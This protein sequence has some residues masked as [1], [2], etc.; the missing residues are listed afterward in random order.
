MIIR[1]WKLSFILV[2]LVLIPSTLRWV[3][4]LFHF[5]FLNEKEMK[6][7]LKCCQCL[8]HHLTFLMLEHEYYAFKSLTFTRLISHNLISWVCTLMI[9]QKRGWS[10]TKMS[11]FTIAWWS[12]DT[13]FI[14][15][16][17]SFFFI[18]FSTN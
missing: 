10:E 4:K 3:R 2:L 9:Q 16:S 6:H 17:F 7:Y 18:Y 15:K 5:S 11:H 12:T 1:T 13:T 8:H 14:N